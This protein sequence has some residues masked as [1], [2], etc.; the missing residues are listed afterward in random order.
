MLIFLRHA[1]AFLAVPKT[2]TTAVEMALSSQA[3][4]IFARNR[5]HITAQRYRRKIAPFIEDTFGVYPDP[6]AVMRDPVDQIRSWYKYR[7]AARLDG[8][9]V[10]TAE[11]SFDHF[12]EAL[13]S[14]DPP[15]Y[16]QIGS[17]FNFLT[18][19]KGRVRVSHLFCHAQ[20]EV[21]TD[22]LS[23]RFGQ[24]V[25]IAPRNVSPQVPAP[26]DPGLEAQLRA[27]RA[28]EFALYQRLHAA[29]GQLSFASS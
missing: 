2:G 8:T 22:F 15:P 17:Q 18:D 5:K 9:P 3:E 29:G 19:K 20:P 28:P 25:E 10:S 11:I 13:L 23:A 14:D 6:V 7:T 12:V 26:L 21:F 16:A 1:L 27:A 24:Q 4:V